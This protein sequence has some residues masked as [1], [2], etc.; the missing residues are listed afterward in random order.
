MTPNSI[1]IG[2]AVTITSV[3]ELPTNGPHFDT[4][5]SQEENSP[6]PARWPQDV[7]NDLLAGRFDTPSTWS[8]AIESPSEY[9]E[10]HE[11][12]D[13][14]NLTNHNTTFGFGGSEQ[15]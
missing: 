4:I 10:A 1:I 6:V 2:L 15:A 9:A 5:S 8:V 13:V 11:N 7:I 14:D 3:V 12:E